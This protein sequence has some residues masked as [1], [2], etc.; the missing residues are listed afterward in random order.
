[1]MPWLPGLRRYLRQAEVLARYRALAGLPEDTV[2]YG[3]HGYYARSGFPV[4]GEP[5]SIPEGWARHEVYHVLAN[6]NTNHQGELL[7][8][9]FIGGNT[10]EMCLDIVLPALIQLHAGKQFVPGPV[11]EGLLRPDAFFRAVARGAA[12]NVDLLDGWRLWDVTHHRLKE[13]RQHYGIPPFTEQERRFLL[14]EDALLVNE[15]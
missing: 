2:G 6:Y 11:G 10:D 8:A 13:L 7:L 4:P 5:G 3:V 15:L 1:M 12:M 9:G 14:A